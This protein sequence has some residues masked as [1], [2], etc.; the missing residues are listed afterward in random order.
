LWEEGGLQAAHEHAASAVVRAFVDDMMSAL[1]VTTGA[2]AIVMTTLA[3]ELHELGTLLAAA[4]AAGDGW[5]VAYLGPNLPAEQIALVARQK[6][7]RAIGLSLVFPENE[8][9]LGDE[10]SRLRRHIG[11]GIAIIAGGRGVATVSE[12][13]DDIDA[14]RVADLQELRQILLTVMPAAEEPVG[15]HAR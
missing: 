9:A 7:A 3:G 2:P 5:D 8:A 4:T 12:T 15:D 6:G 13:L 1:E 11:P 14:I 10:L